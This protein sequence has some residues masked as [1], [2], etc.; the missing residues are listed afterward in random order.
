MV[1][2]NPVMYPL[3]E[4]VRGMALREWSLAGIGRAMI[5]LS[6][7]LRCPRRLYP[8]WTSLW[9]IEAII[10]C[11]GGGVGSTVVTYKAFIVIE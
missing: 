3:G 9:G 6:A 5:A 10:V 4:N 8:C 11:L 2:L 7:L 1:R